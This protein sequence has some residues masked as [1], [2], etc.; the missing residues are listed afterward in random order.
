MPK[1]TTTI[2]ALA[3]VTTFA[4]AQIRATTAEEIAAS[5]VV[6]TYE[7][8]KVI[9]VGSETGS[10]SVGYAL[11][12]SIV[13]VDRAGNSVDEHL[14]KPGAQIRVCFEAN[15]KS[16]V[17]KRVVVDEDGLNHN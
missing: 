14:I 10:D 12:K 15:G 11:D 4:L 3:L 5:D 17:I 16:R 7:P 13:Y 9:V 2:L 6:T 8:G 1:K